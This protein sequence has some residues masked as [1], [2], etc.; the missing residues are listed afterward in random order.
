MMIHFVFGLEFLEQVKQPEMVLCGRARRNM[1]PV[2]TDNL[3]CRRS[4]HELLHLPL[5]SI[6]ELL[7]CITECRSP[8]EDI[9][10][11]PN[12]LFWIHI[13][14]SDLVELLSKLEN[15]NIG[16]IIEGIL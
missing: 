8:L 1:K 14:I 16:E 10:K 11:A 4:I 7:E 3:I 9:E 15:I 2:C 13:V 12:M 6:V 5:H